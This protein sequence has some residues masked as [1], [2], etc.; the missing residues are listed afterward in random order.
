[1]II[2]K[3]ISSPNYNERK[4]DTI[5]MLVIH[6]TD[7]IDIMES[8]DILTHPDKE[9]SAHYLIDIN[10]DIIQMVDESMRAWH[11]G[12]S[13][14]R[15]ITDINSHSIGIELQNPGHG[16]G[17]VEFPDAQM[18]SLVVLCK[19]IL[20]RHE[21][22][23]LNIVAHSD[24]APARKKDPGELFDWAF[25]SRNGIGLYPEAAAN[26]DSPKAINDILIE[27]G[28]DPDVSDDER[29]TAFKR[30]FGW[31]DSDAELKQKAVSLLST[32]Q[33]A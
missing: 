6:Y 26:M 11:A 21:I 33:P 29:L 12:K 31:N 23:A 30:H 22:P 14:W 20:E 5:D 9:V 7:T 16:N 15:G 2:T 10:G 8:I 24:I 17:Y 25:L 27:I 19:D 28:Y 1:M 4:A 32:S 18:D 3:F 13:F